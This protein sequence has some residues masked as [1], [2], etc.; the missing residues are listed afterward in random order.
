M[1][2]VSF[3]DVSI[4]LRMVEDLRAK[5]ETYNVLSTRDSS[6][7]LLDQSM[8]MNRSQDNA[9]GLFQSGPVLEF[10]TPSQV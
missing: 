1:P 4:T 3:S 8:L 9:W 6:T 5:S 2:P 10:D 7:L